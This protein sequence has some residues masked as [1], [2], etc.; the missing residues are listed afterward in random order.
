MLFKVIFS[1]IRNPSAV[2]A[3]FLP[4]CSPPAHRSAHRSAHVAP[5]VGFLQL[6]EHLRWDYKVL[7]LYLL[8]ANELRHICIL[9]KVLILVF[10]AIFFTRIYNI[11]VVWR[12]KQCEH[13]QENMYS[14]SQIF[15]CTYHGYFMHCIAFTYVYI[16][17]KKRIVWI[18]AVE[19]P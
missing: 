1:V 10:Y 15:K 19:V 12:S 4:L 13:E 14:A 16:Q 8:S 9:S 17:D 5:A 7:V 11:I 3:N 6:P 2:S 18:G